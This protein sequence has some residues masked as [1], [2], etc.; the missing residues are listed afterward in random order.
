MIA[1]M[2]LIGCRQSHGG[3]GSPDS[4]PDGSGGFPPPRDDL[5]AA[6]GSAESL[7]IATWNIENFPRQFTTAGQV[8]DVITSLDLDLIAVQEIASVSAFDELVAR[9]PEHEGLLS[10]HVYGN[11]EY[12]KVGFLYRAALLTPSAQELLFTD[13]TYSFPRPPLQVRFAVNTGTQGDPL[14]FTAIVVHLKAGVDS[15]DAERR[16][17]AVALLEAHIRNAVDGAA[18]D[19]AILLGDFNEVFT[20]A[21]GQEVWA[22]F[23]DDPDHYRVHTTSLDPGAHSFLPWER[24]LDHVVSTSALADEFAEGSVQIPRLDQQIPGYEN[25]ISDHLPVVTIMPGVGSEE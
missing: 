12:Q 9:L 19:D 13:D 15:W 20:T 7:D 8:A 2:A 3:G 24:I 10:E 23:L 4:G 16:Q 17:Q 25:T 18:D 14:D 21:S 22:P 6:V 5:V 11:G 1:C